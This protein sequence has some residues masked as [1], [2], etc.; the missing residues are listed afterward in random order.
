M[1][2]YV[3]QFIHFYYYVVT[4]F[5]TNGI[6]FSIPLDGHLGFSDLGLFQTLLL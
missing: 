4:H 2:L 6:Y 5:M 3:V 1:F